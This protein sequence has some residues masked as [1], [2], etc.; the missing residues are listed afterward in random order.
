MKKIP[1]IIKSVFF[2]IF[3]VLNSCSNPDE[4]Y[5]DIPTTPVVVD[6]T[7]VPYPKLSDTRAVFRN[8]TGC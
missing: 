1:K 5:I 3:L 7:D 4:E 6:L 2:G 8:I